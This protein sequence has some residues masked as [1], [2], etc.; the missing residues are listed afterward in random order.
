M[1]N[2]WRYLAVI[3]LLLL[4]PLPGEGENEELSSSTIAV[5]VSF[6]GTNVVRADLELLGND[7]SVGL[8]TGDDHIIV[9]DPEE[10][11]PMMDWIATVI[12]VPGHIRSIRLERGPG[13]TVMLDRP[14]MGMIRAVSPYE[15]ADPI[16]PWRGSGTY[17]ADP[18]RLSHIGH[19]LKGGRLLSVY[20]LWICP[21][22]L[23]SSGEAT[24]H[25]TTEVH[26]DW[27]EDPIP[28]RS[29]GSP[30]GVPGTVSVT[31]YMEVPPSYIIVTGE[32]L[33]GSLEP[34]ARWRS[35][36]GLPTSIIAV[37]DILVAYPGRE[38]PADAIREYLRDVHY[39][40][41]VLEHVL[42]AGDWDIVPTK[43]V[44]DAN[45]YPGWDDGYL[46]ADFYFACL[47]GTWDL[48]GDGIFAEI[49][50]LEDIVPDISVSRLAINEGSVWEA[51]VEQIIEYEMGPGDLAWSDRAV[52]IA[53]HTHSEGD[54]PAHSEY[55][56]NKHLSGHYG[57]KVELY[58]SDMDLT[59]NAVDSALA[60]GAGFVQFIDHGGPTVW[61]D[62]Y[63]SGVIYRDRDASKLENDA[64]MPLVSTLAC[65]TTWF[66]DSSGS[67]QWFGECIG[68]SFTE[69]VRGGAAGYAGSSRT[70][71]GIIGMNRYLPYVNGLQ[72]DLARQVGSLGEYVMGRAFKDA[73]GHYAEVWGG[74]F[75]NSGN[76]EV[77]M[78]WLEYNMLGE[79]ALELWT[80]PVNSFDVEIRHEND[81]DPH[82]IVEVRDRDNLPVPGVNVT[83]ENFQMG[84]F[85]NG[86][87]DQFGEAAFDLSIR[88]FCEINVSARKHDHRPVVTAF[89]V[90]DT[91]P[92]TSFLTTDPSEP[93]GE[94]GWFHS[95]VSVRIAPDEKGVVHARIGAGTTIELNE[96][97]DFT[98]T[99]E[100]E[101]EFQVHYFAEDIAKNLEQERHHTIRIDLK[102]PA[103][104][105]YTSPETPDGKGGHYISEPMITITPVYDEG[106]P[107]AALHSLDGGPYREYDGPFYVPDGSHVLRVYAVDGSGRSSNVTET[108][109]LIDSTPPEASHL[110][111]PVSP[112]GLDSWYRTRPLL[113]LE[114]SED[115]ASVQFRLDPR[116]DFEP[117]SAPIRLPEGSHTLQYRAFDAAGNIGLVHTYPVLVDASPPV[118]EAFV[119]PDEPDGRNG[120]HVTSPRVEM[121]AYDNIASEV[122][123][124][125]DQGPW[126]GYFSSIRIDEGEHELEA[127]AVD[128]AG[129][130]SPMF[131]RTLKVDTNP[132]I[133]IME[134]SGDMTNG[135]F[136]TAPVISLSS[137]EDVELFYYFGGDPVR[138][139]GS[140]PMPGEEGIYLLNYF[141][142]DLA[143]NAG[144][145]GL[146]E[147]RYDVLAPR[148]EVKTSRVGRNVL[149]LS[150]AGTDDAF[151]VE[152]RVVEG[153]R[154]LSDWSPATERTIEAGTGKHYLTVEA[155]DAAGNRETASVTF[156][157]QCR[158][159]IFVLAGVL[160]LASAASAAFFIIRRR[161]RDT[162][163]RASVEAYEID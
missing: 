96:T 120:I 122:R 14:V 158:V 84:V 66:D 71:V 89:R 100:E 54:G 58:E 139:E 116:S 36:R 80:G 135:I 69:N 112:D 115:G 162:A 124:R 24:A 93:E 133:A 7:I 155:R 8:L 141:A 27:E 23:S 74:Q 113:V 108:S 50:D 123:Y 150:M 160:L 140:V 110:L 57:D 142:V 156:S 31:P 42:L 82:V 1:P 11:S 131:R 152:Y 45:P 48:D 117:Y 17:P 19:R 144:E 46:P 2:S 106:A 13:R 51:K 79:T 4:V 68:E 5:R 121:K 64:M 10:G 95:P 92:P 81:L 151:P 76:S 16:L 72:E 73:K 83:L 38:D 34:L 145:V 44:Q 134:L 149:I 61:C 12:T 109:F 77:S 148:L 147:I 159:W 146:S 87:T 32:Y 132:P 18:L 47:D 161:E 49:G 55:L 30:E 103:F 70:S 35:G 26:I 20:S 9:R 101:G 163:D 98:F 78:C 25:P 105:M 99:L 29:S 125:I 88:W 67:D 28:A 65:L 154:V 157:V 102:D 3:L 136:R 107:V 114:S 6:D 126:T 90:A 37:E 39:G 127:Y 118:L 137:D 128:P 56:W 40:W 130:Q 153:G 94:N 143:G 97:N 43:R 86:V 33:R 104:E 53:A 60:P 75:K 22:T 15:E 63:G 59:I 91:I 138:Y 119:H 41:G 111:S 62:N 129:W 85:A 21:M 52:L